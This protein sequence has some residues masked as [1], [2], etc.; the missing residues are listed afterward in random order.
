MSLRRSWSDLGANDLAERHRE[1]LFVV[2]VAQPRMYSLERQP[3]DSAHFVGMGLVSLAYVAHQI[4][5]HG[6]GN[7]LLLAIDEEVAGR[8][9]IGD[10]LR[11][12]PRL[13]LNLA[14]GRL[15][16]RLA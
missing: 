15:L 3:L 6:F 12:H 4:P 8:G 16:R 7:A 2:L 1:E 14:H 11:K 13:L 9:K 5:R 10:D